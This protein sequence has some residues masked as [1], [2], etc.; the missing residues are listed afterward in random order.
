MQGAKRCDWTEHLK[1][2]YHFLFLFFLDYVP[3]T[4]VMW[5]SCCNLAS[6]SLWYIHGRDMIIIQMLIMVYSLDSLYSKQNRVLVLLT[7]TSRCSWQISTQSESTHWIVPSPKVCRVCSILSP[8]QYL[9]WWLACSDVSSCVDMGWKR[10]LEGMNSAVRQFG[11]ICFNTIH[12]TNKQM[13]K[14]ENSCRN[15]SD[16]S[17]LWCS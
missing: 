1:E 2:L 10:D 4:G 5:V 8:L 11:P 15:V 3:F 14:L 9:G 12:V 16:Y 7:L 17:Y 6:S 13:G